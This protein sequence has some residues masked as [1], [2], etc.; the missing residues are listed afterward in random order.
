MAKFNEQQRQII[1]TN[2]I[3]AIKS[4]GNGKRVMVYCSSKEGGQLVAGTIQA[5]YGYKAV[6]AE[7]ILESI[8]G[9]IGLGVLGPIGT[10][11]GIATE[12]WK[13]FSVNTGSK[14]NSNKLVK[15]IN[16]C[17]TDYGTGGAG[18]AV[19][20]SLYTGG[21]DGSGSSGSGIG[22]TA[23]YLIAGATVAIVLAIVLTRKKK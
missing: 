6:K 11:V 13:N 5:A 17:I 16:S 21:D 12:T 7:N 14:E 9:H 8:V 3:S 23:V 2:C 19:D 15:A 4:S 20:T 1:G 22:K 10:G 18:G